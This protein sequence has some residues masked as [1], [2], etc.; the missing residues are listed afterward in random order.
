M[1]LDLH[2]EIHTIPGLAEV[3]LL[4]LFGSKPNSGHRSSG[5]CGFHPLKLEVDCPDSDSP[6]ILLGLG[7]LGSGSSVPN[8]R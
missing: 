6:L 1:I 3:V 7:P 2:N 5:T 8:H 4:P